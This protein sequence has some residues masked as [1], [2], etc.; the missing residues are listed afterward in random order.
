MTTEEIITT[1]YLVAALMMTTFCW[2][3]LRD[4]W[5]YRLICSV[6]VGAFWPIPACLIVFLYLEG[7]VV[8]I[9]K[10]LDNNL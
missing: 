10:W 8:D 2:S 4:P 5:Y 1:I 7:V 3:R 6:V 9:A